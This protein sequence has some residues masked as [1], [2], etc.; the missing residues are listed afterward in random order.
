MSDFDYNK[1]VATM[2]DALRKRR[3]LRQSMDLLLTFCES[4]APD[5]TALWTDLRTRDYEADAQQIQRS[6]Q[7]SLRKSPIPTD[8]TG[9]YFGLDGLN[10]PRGKGIEFGC[11]KAFDEAQDDG[12]V[13]WAYK[14][15]FYP[16]KIPSPLLSGLYDGV[17][18]MA[19]LADFAICISYTGLAIR[20]ALDALPLHLTLGD[21]KARAVCFGP[22]DGD[23]F[24]LGTLRAG[25]LDVLA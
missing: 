24:R 8:Y 4:E 2:R 5:D 3:D 11:S 10:M 25:G 7:K 13:T 23:L 12:G 6:L 1:T 21:A 9:L 17:V 19:S 20:D 15:D 14:G 16:F 18:E 22:N